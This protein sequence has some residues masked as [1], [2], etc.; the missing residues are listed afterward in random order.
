[1]AQPLQT[2]IGLNR[3]LIKTYTQNTQG[4]VHAI[5]P[6]DNDNDH[7]SVDEQQTVFFTNISECFMNPVI[8]E[9]NNIGERFHQLGLSC[10]KDMVN[11]LKVELDASF[12]IIANAMVQLENVVKS[13]MFSMRF[14]QQ[15]SPMPTINCSYPRTMRWPEETELIKALSYCNHEYNEDL[16]RSIMI[17]RNSLHCLDEFYATLRERRK[18]NQK[19]VLM[20]CCENHRYVVE[21]LQCVHVVERLTCYMGEMPVYLYRLQSGLM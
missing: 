16:I 18:N 9:L 6:E 11:G 15:S 17:C 19:Y 5:I 7:L 2:N 13:N 20:R 10:V 3:N 12:K 14:L 8:K 1:M 21:N 4:I